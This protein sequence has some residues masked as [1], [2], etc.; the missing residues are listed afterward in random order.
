MIEFGL[1]PAVLSFL[2]IWELLEVESLIQ[3]RAEAINKRLRAKLAVWA[4]MFVNKEI[5][6]NVEKQYNTEPQTTNTLTH[7]EVAFLLKMPI[8]ICD[9]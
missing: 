1:F 6:C 3:I 2:S 9:T 5:W 4:D 7:Q 8:W